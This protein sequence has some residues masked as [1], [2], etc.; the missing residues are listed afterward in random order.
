MLY[1]NR[2][3]VSSSAIIMA[4]LI[5][6]IAWPKST[7]LRVLGWCAVVLVIQGWLQ[8]TT[9]SYRKQSTSD[10][11]PHLWAGRFARASVVSGAVWGAAAFVLVPDNQ[12][13]TLALIAVFPL[14]S[15]S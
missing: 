1:S 14:P 3:A 6:I 2:W 8:L 5:A 13:L 4:V 9:V 15:T 7:P 12:P 11:D 10:S